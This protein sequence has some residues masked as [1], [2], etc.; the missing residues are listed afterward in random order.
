M[1]LILGPLFVIS[2]PWSI[3][4]E[5][6]WSIWSLLLLGGLHFNLTSVSMR[7]PICLEPAILLEPFLTGLSFLHWFRFDFWGKNKYGLDKYPLCVNF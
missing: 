2:L 7:I 1:A 6:F 4:V 5:K 3:M